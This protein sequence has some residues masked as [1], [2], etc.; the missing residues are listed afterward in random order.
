M[1]GIVAKGLFKYYGSLKALDDVSFEIN[2]GE[3]FGFLGPNGAGKT[4]T[5]EILE[6]L[7]KPDEGEVLID[8][9]NLTKDY[10]KIKQI[11]GV[12]L[13]SSSIYD[14]IK[15]IEALK[16]FAGY[17]K[18]PVNIDE[19][20]DIL[21]LRDKQNTYFKDLSGGQKQRLSLGL[22]LVNDPKVV[23]LDEPT[24][25]IDPHARRNLWQIIEKMKNNNKTVVLTTHYMEEAQKL[26]NRIAIMDRGK[27][28][29]LDTPRA[30][31]EKRNLKSTI[32]VHFTNEVNI[33]LLYNID[34]VSEVK[35][36]G[37][38]A[39]LFTK[40]S[41]G[42]ITALT[43]MA[44]KKLLFIEKMIVKEANLEDLFLE[45]TGRDLKE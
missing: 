31:I 43:D 5:L 40:D 28:I 42:V 15:V 9:K 3:V 2:Q 17:Y 8:D 38:T 39:T 6:G 10:Y 24:A 16:V 34:G 1:P 45:L 44:K 36:L 25:G 33:S 19:L 14:K 12:Q 35:L 18:N 21:S 7:R 29:D 26:C 30:L 11:I 13:Q 23:F 37:Y 32:S 22:A 27:I 4:T 20:L 41:M